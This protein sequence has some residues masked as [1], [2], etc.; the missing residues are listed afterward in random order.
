MTK[1]QLKTYIADISKNIE[2]GDAADMASLVA[3]HG[4][5]GQPGIEKSLDDDLKSQMKEIWLSLKA[6]GA[7]VEDPPLLFGL[8][9]DFESAGSVAEEIE[10]PSKALVEDAKKVKK[11]A[12][13]NNAQEEDEGKAASGK[14]GGSTAAKKKEKSDKDGDEL[15][16]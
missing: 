14:S 2:S 7:Q 11:K 12:E 8:P 6:G 15:P 1:K 13:K 4:I 16:H 9:E 5:L 3:I 10:I